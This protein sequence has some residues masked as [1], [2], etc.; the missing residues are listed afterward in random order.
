MSYQATYVWSKGLSDCVNT[1]CSSWVNAVDRKFNKTLQPSD[2]RH[3]FRVN[4]TYELPFGPGRLIFGN[5][6]GLLARLTEQWQ[7]GVIANF[8]SGA[9]LNVTGSNTYIGNGRLDIVGPFAKDQGQ[10]QMTSG[11]PTYF[12]VGTYKLT[13]DPQCAAVTAL[14]STNAS[15]TL[16]SITDS[17][18]RILLQ[19]A[20]PGRLGNLGDGW[21]TGPG[22]FRF[23]MSASKS[24]RITETKSLQLRIDA[25]NVLNTPILGSPNLNINSADFGQIPATQVTGSRQFQGQLR[26]NF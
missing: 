18:G 20:V 9:P 24:V 22:S 1:T 8:N 19:H 26:V 3:D 2:R 17:Q 7:L 21:I 14:Q 15:C 12:P 10:A 11:L 5:S 6:N 16:N 13:P 25:R 23:D 4:G